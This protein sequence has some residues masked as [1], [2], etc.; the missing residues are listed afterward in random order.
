MPWL[1]S[2]LK[3]IDT[4]KELVSYIGGNTQ[5]SRAVVTYSGGEIDSSVVTVAELALLS[6]VSS[7]AQ[8]QLTSL[9]GDKENSITGAATSATSANLTSSRVLLS[10]GSGKIS[11][12]GA[13][14]TTFAY[15]DPTSSIQSQMNSKQSEITTSSPL[16]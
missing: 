6:G 9:E 5:P 2:T 7:N 1:G 8:T 12:S 11:A 3:P 14:A 13:T 10:D 16:S 15:L 4:R